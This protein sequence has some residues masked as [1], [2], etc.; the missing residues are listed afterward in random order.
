VT[1]PVALWEDA[2][3]FGQW[4]LEPFACLLPLLNAQE[5]VP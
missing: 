5:I 3:Q 1:G 4:Y 2:R